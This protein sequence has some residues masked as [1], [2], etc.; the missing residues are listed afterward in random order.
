MY[1]NNGKIFCYVTNKSSQYPQILMYNLNRIYPEF[2]RYAF[3]R[4]RELWAKQKH[5]GKIK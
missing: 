4:Q 3:N 2:D 1:D 5:R